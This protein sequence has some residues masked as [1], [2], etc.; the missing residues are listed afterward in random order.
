MFWTWG[1]CILSPCVLHSFR[2]TGCAQL[3]VDLRNTQVDLR[4]AQIQNNLSDNNY[5]RSSDAILIAELPKVLIFGCFSR[6]NS[7]FIRFI[8]AKVKSFM[9]DCNAGKPHSPFLIPIYSFDPI[10]VS[11]AIPCILHILALTYASQVRFSVVSCIMINM[12]N[13]LIFRGIHDKPMEIKI[14]SVHR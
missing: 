11:S 13:D 14:P 3:S 6:C 2:L 12:V 5:R 9:I 1:C 8:G 4:N 10:N 7:F